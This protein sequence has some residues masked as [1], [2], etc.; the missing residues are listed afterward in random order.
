MDFFPIFLKLT[1]QPVLI[2]GGGAV[3]ERKARLLQRAGAQITVLAPS[4]C[5]SLAQYIRAHGFERITADYSARSLRGYRLV[6]AATDRPAVNRQVYLD[7][8]AQGVLVNSV[9]DFEHCRFITP[10]IIDRSPVQVAISSGGRSPS[11]TRI[12]RRWIEQRLP[13]GLGKVAI[14]AG[15][16]RRRLK[17]A[18]QALP[19]LRRR[20]DRALSD[21]SI[22]H[23][24]ADGSASIQVGQIE[25]ELRQR[26]LGQQTLSGSVSLVGAGP[27]NPDLLTLRALQ[28]LQTADVVLHDRLIAPEILDRI[29]RDATVIDVGKRCA[30]R[31]TAQNQIH[32]LLLKYAREGR[33]VVRLKGGDPFIFGRGGEELEFLREHGVPV[34][35]VPG[36]TAALGCAAASGIPLTHRD[37]SHG[38]TFLTGHR[39]LRQFAGSWMSTHRPG[40]TAVVYMG[41][42]QAADIRRQLLDEAVPADLPVAIVSGG[43][44]ARQQTLTG[45]L[46]ELDKLA[47]RVA[48][49]SPALLIIGEIAA[50]ARV[51]ENTPSKHPRSVQLNGPLAA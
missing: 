50:L 49:R 25:D 24:G 13:S 15:A 44:T 37:I 40:H 16:L 27:G 28:L 22:V 2:V 30:G 23:W 46:S 9:D 12:L 10:A 43:T 11:L 4:V 1:S 18:G 6:I 51:Q 3:A 41:L 14:A 29:R 33:Q 48:D 5:P 36:V 20:W 45:C 21:Q 8:E 32:A 34:E 31:R 17:A 19:N 26:L 47:S 39:G 35:V 38:V 42:R 7:A